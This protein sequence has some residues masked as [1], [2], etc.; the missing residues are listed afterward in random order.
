MSDTASPIINIEA[1]HIVWPEVRNGMLSLIAAEITSHTLKF[2]CRSTWEIDWY[3][4]QPSKE[5]ISKAT[6]L[7]DSEFRSAPGQKLLCN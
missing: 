2:F 5:L 1:A 4:I 7:R 3:Q 6:K